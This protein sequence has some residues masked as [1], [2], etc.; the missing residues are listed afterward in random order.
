MSTTSELRYTI[1]TYL[2]A[3]WRKR[4]LIGSILLLTPLLGLFLSHI[5]PKM[6]EASTSL[7]MFN[8]TPVFLKD[9][10][11]IPEPETR[12]PGIKAYATSPE[13]LK[14]IA[15]KVGLLKPDATEK[16][17]QG[18]TK[19]LAKAITITL[20][21][22]NLVDIKLTYYNPKE[23]PAILNALSST[24]ITEY[25]KPITASA[26]SLSVLLEKELP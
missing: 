9:V 2:D 20:I 23:M 22:K 18:L 7:A 25:L 15:M 13:N 3:L 10:S 8:S 5:S 6:Y 16:E 4:V 12:Y 24:F 19:T 1:F 26:G 11:S 17:I 21:E 14:K